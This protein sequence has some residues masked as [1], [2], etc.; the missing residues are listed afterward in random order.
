MPARGMMR[1]GLPADG[2]EIQTHPVIIQRRS[3]ET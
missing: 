3:D 1:G 2:P